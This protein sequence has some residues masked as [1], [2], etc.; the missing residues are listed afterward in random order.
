MAGGLTNNRLAHLTPPQALEDRGIVEL[1]L[2]SDNKDGLSKGIVDGGTC[3][4]AVCR[5]GDR[6]RDG[7]LA[8]LC[9]LDSLSHKR[10]SDACYPV[11]V[12]LGPKAQGLRAGGAAIGGLA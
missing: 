12:G 10:V 8:W 5:D 9:S 7:G 6:G 1:L 4:E 3:L 2:T 11:C